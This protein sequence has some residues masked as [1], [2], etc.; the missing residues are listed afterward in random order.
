MFCKGF[1][2]VGESFRKKGFV[3]C[4][5]CKRVLFVWIVSYFF[6]E[7]TPSSSV[8]KAFEER[9]DFSMSNITYA[10]SLTILNPMPKNA[11]AHVV[12]SPL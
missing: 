11:N 3:S 6:V 4:P 5:G 2:V 12:V 1:L 10:I 8:A 9:E 7:N